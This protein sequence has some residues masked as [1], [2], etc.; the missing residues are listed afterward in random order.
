MYST[1]FSVC[2]KDHGLVVMV[3]VEHT[4][5]EMEMVNYMLHYK[6]NSFMT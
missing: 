5:V 4:V 1:I 2:K 3:M 6:L